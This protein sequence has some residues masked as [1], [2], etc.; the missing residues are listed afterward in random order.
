MDPASSNAFTPNTYNAGLFECLEHKESCM[1]GCC[2]VYCQVSAQ[3]N[4]LRFKVEGVDMCQ[5]CLMVCGDAV[6]FHGLCLLFHATTQRMEITMLGLQEGCLKACCKTWCCML[7]S[8]CQIHREMSIRHHFPGGVCVNLPYTKPGVEAPKP[9]MM[10]MEGGGNAV[11]LVYPQPIM[12][13]QPGMYAQ[14]CMMYAQPGVQFPPGQY[15]QHPQMMMP[16]PGMGYRP[17]PVPHKGA[18]DV[19]L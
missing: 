1:D 18:P 16:Q 3:R 15:P 9:H 6:F 4:R 2:C 17:P 19:P 5:C 13:A 11:P 10:S 14:P 7:C 12:V 8:A